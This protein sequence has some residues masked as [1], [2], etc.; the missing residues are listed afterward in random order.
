MFQRI[1]CIYIVEIAQTRYPYGDSDMFSGIDCTA[2]KHGWIA[3]F[4]FNSD[5]LIDCSV[6]AFTSVEHLVNF[7][8]LFYLCLSETF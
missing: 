8:F 7:K 2:L 5:D 4:T 1:S 6:R 3:I